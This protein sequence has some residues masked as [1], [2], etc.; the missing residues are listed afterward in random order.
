[1]SQWMYLWRPRRIM[2]IGW[3]VISAVYSP[4]VS[5]TVSVPPAASSQ[6]LRPAIGA[7][8]SGHPPPLVAMSSRVGSR[9]RCEHTLPTVRSATPGPATI[10]GTLTERSKNDILK[11]APRSPSMS[12]WSLVAITTVSSMRPVSPRTCTRRPTHESK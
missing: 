8:S 11:N 1:M 12:P 6:R 4:V 10:S 9:S 7:P 2:K 3:E 5:S